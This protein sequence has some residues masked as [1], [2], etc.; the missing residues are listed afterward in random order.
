MKINYN[1]YLSLL[2]IIGILSASEPNASTHKKGSP[3]SSRFCVAFQESLSHNQI[4]SILDRYSADVIEK[5]PSISV[6][7]YI[8]KIA[9]QRNDN[10]FVSNT[11]NRLDN[12]PGILYVT[13]EYSDLKE[14]TVSFGNVRR[15]GNLGISRPTKASFDD[16]SLSSTTRYQDIVVSHF[17]G[18][19]RCLSPKSSQKKTGHYAQFNINIDRGGSV[20]QV[21]VLKTNIRDPRVLNCLRKKIY[22]WRNFPERQGPRDLHVKFKFEY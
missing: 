12:E 11:L 22:T 5:M 4:N 1:I 14:Q 6:P 18:L 19:Y 21:R 2:M 16:K 7:V 8:V 20:S 10:S 15:Q 3:S 9:N 17:E 13:S